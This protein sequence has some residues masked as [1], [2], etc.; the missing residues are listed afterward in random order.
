MRKGF[1]NFTLFHLSCSFVTINNE[2]THKCTHTHTHQLRY[3]VNTHVHADHVTGSGELKERFKA[4]KSAT[5][6]VQSIITRSSGARA[7]VLVEE[8]DVISIGKAVNLRVLST[9]G[10]CSIFR[11]LAFFSRP[12]FIDPFFS[13]KPLN[14]K[15][16]FFCLTPFLYAFSPL[17]VIP[18]DAWL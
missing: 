7:D 17:K 4:L 8:N 9:P 18:A 3:V 13:K 10:K 1:D 16:A 14:W 2:N 11:K 12:F 15:L 5:P 6:N